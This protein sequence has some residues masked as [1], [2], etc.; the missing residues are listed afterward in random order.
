ML[1]LVDVEQI[2][3]P[4]DWL[5]LIANVAVEFFPT[6]EQSDGGNYPLGKLKYESGG[7]VGPDECCLGVLGL[8]IINWFVTTEPW[9]TQRPPTGPIAN[10]TNR[11]AMRVNLH[12]V[13]CVTGPTSTGGPPDAAVALREQA[14]LTNLGWG[15]YN[16]YLTA[17]G[18]LWRKHF[19][20]ARVGSFS[21]KPVAGG[22]SGFT[23]DFTCQLP[24]F[25]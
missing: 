16:A 11:G 3:T 15:L 1:A 25:C 9:P 23:I 10:N 4:T 19:G 24:A 14:D 20:A 22:C 18:T 2:T 17:E 13:T 21:R 5:D 6:F 7:A 12:Y 8:D